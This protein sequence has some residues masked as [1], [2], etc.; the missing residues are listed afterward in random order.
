MLEKSYSSSLHVAFI[1][2]KKNWGEKPPPP[3]RPV[4]QSTLLVGVVDLMC[5]PVP[6]GLLS[7]GLIRHMCKRPDR[8]QEWLWTRETQWNQ[9]LDL[10]LISNGIKPIELI[11]HRHV[12]L[13]WPT[14]DALRVIIIIWVT[15]VMAEARLP[16]WRV[17]LFSEWQSTH[18]VHHNAGGRTD[19]WCRKGA[20]GGVWMF[21]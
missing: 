13:Q 7:W 1:T 17:P 11:G 15:S 12:T 21:F 10:G 2:I 5:P 16:G 20:P 18:S 8:G 9:I 4:L 14:D 19:L 6:S 3:V